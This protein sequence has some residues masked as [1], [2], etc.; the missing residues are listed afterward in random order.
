[1]NK[2]MPLLIFNT[3]C[4]YCGCKNSI[5]ETDTF[6]I[7][8]NCNNVFMIR[9]NTKDDICLEDMYSLSKLEDKYINNDKRDLSPF[10]YIK[11]EKYKKKK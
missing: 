3:D 6:P 2:I 5:I 11:L 7:C 1:M 8:K 4:P 9:K 10:L